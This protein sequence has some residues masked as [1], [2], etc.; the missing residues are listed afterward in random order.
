MK[1]VLGMLFV[2][3]GVTTGWLVL[4]GKLPNANPTPPSNGA[5]IAGNTITDSQINSRY[6]NQNASTGSYTMTNMGH[7]VGGPQSV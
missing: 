1:A 2:L 7:S 5:S 3:A 4:S 6:R